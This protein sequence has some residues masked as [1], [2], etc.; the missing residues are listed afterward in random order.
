MKKFNRGNFLL[1]TINFHVHVEAN[2]LY[3]FFFKF[4]ISR[5]RNREHAKNTRLRK[6]VYVL[7]L[8][9]LVEQIKLQKEVEESEKRM[10]AV[11]IADVVRAF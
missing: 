1:L 10:L 7:K 11:R 5:H 2:K 4:K 6:K 8:R 3:S 9:D